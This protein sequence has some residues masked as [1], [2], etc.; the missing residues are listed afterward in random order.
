MSHDGRDLLICGPSGLDVSQIVPGV[1]AGPRLGAEVLPGA[2]L[3][4]P[5]E[6]PTGLALE[7]VAGPDTGRSLPMS[8]G[9]HGIGRGEIADPALS[10]RHDEVAV[11][12][13]GVVITDAGST[14]G[15]VLLDPQTDTASGLVPGR[16][17]RLDIGHELLAGDSRL[18]LR[19][20]GAAPP[21]V[22]VDGRVAYARSP[23][24]I[25]APAAREFEL[26]SPPT[27][28]TRAPFPLVTV[29]LP[30]LAAVPLAFFMHSPMWLL[31]GLLSPVMMLGNH[32]EARRTGRH[33]GRRERERVAR[34]RRAVG[35]AM[36]RAVAD[37][38][39]WRAVAFPD[40]AEIV[41]LCTDRTERLWER[42][43]TDED[44]LTV[45]VGIG[46]VASRHTVRG[47]RRSEP[48]TLRETPV[49]LSL[50]EFPLVGVAGPAAGGIVSGWLLQLVALHSPVAMELHVLGVEDAWAWIRW[51][52]H[53]WDAPA[54]RIAADPADVEE[55]L[56][57][58]AALVDSRTTPG[59]V[60]ADPGPRVVVL[61]ADPGRHRHSEALQRLLTAGP[62]A[63]VSL[64][65][66]AD[67]AEDLPGDLAVVVS[68][69]RI[70][71][72]D[73]PAQPV[74]VDR[75]APDVAEPAARALAP[76]RDVTPAGRGG[77]LPPAVGLAEVLGL[78]LFDEEALVDAVTAAWQAPGEEAVLGMLA[79]GPW[80]VDLRRDGPHLLIAGT[81]GSGKSELLRTLVTSLALHNAPDHLAFVLVDYKGGA[82]FGACAALPHVTGV[83]TDLDQAGTAR[84]IESLA[85]EIRRREGLLAAAGVADLDAYRRS[86]ESLP[87][88]VV[89]LDE[90]RVL[91]EEQPE[92]LADLVRLATVGRSLGL[93]LV[94]ATQRPGGVVSA[95]MN[96]NLNLRIALRVQNPTESTDVLGLPDA[97][98][99]PS[100]TPGRA[101]ARIG[102]EPAA[103]FQ[104]A[105][106]SGGGTGQAT[107]TAAPWIWHGQPPPVQATHD[108]A[109][110]RR[111][112][113]A[114]STAARRTG[115]EPCAP[116]WL[117]PLPAVI[118]PPVA[119]AET[120]PIRIALGRADVPAR[121]AQPT[122]WWEPGND[123]HLLVAGTSRSGRT[124]VLRTLLDDSTS[125]F[126]PD[127][128]W[129]YVLDGGGALADLAPRPG[130]GAVV[131]ADDHERA[132][133]LLALLRRLIAGRT[134]AAGHPA[135]LLLVDSWE[136]VR[137]GR[138]DVAG[139]EFLDDLAA[140]LRD[141]PRVGVH[142]VV[143]GGRSVLTG[144]LAAA[145]PAR[146]LLRP[147]D[148]SDL[149]L[150]GVRAK[151]A[152]SPWPV[153]RGLL[154]GRTADPAPVL[155]QVFRPG[156]GWN[157][158]TDGPGAPTVP[159]MPEHV[160]LH[161]VAAPPGT[162]VLG[163]G[164]D[165]V[166]PLG[167]DP[168]ASPLLVAG[169][170]GTGRTTA[171]TTVATQALAAGWSVVTNTALPL[172][173]HPHLFAPDAADVQRTVEQAPG[174]VLMV[175]DH[176]ERC[177][178]AW[179]E[180]VN[181]AMSGPVV[182]AAAGT[183]PGLVS[184]FSGPVVELR[185]R[186]SVVLLGP[187]ARADTDLV[188][189]RATVR[190]TR[191]PGRGL[192]AEHG[193]LTPIQVVTSGRPRS[194]QPARRQLA[195]VQMPSD[196]G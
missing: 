71:Y 144:Q 89:V 196:P 82:A 58:L 145:V 14:N 181:R 111:L 78:D 39:R 183:T 38:K 22:P 194:Q 105:S 5:T 27:T 91:A 84:V 187:A 119:Q 115:A 37:E 54:P 3:D 83:V 127:R 184:C 176:V 135:V 26:P 36:R 47:T 148:V 190:H 53:L 171:L 19:H 107:P 180:A 152:P 141:G 125:R 102:S 150:A 44:A 188:D 63:G 64:L 162:W 109:N 117:P 139:L 118:E 8:A 55:A 48:V 110:L 158:G 25:V 80:S 123:G 94:L 172:D 87:R 159:V 97:A 137:A 49:S 114:V 29:L 166:L 98:H 154:V 153:G 24:R 42:A 50:V 96:A 191:A 193:R 142:V 75:V 21:I 17:T 7:V 18:T 160:S 52:P 177:A 175:V 149:T 151:D 95:E 182:I 73:A 120:G 33:A 143:T 85:T 56:Q 167:W 40:V 130:L 45:R 165:D 112:V 70:H 146:L 101:I 88:L 122:L 61:L 113:E 179:E 138:D 23:R 34:R 31:F 66:V 12:P 43:A 195:P 116:V 104:V 121:Q 72:R 124:G 106:V 60:K 164:G 51:A 86:G 185:R 140:V 157:G 1:G 20:R 99:L 67:E 126:G 15:T 156:R 108:D 133:R 16:P 6:A 35:E 69:H 59:T 32:L 90:F 79:E 77:T 46:S 92:A 178:A 192:L 10:R 173:A 30:L 155:M 13:T 170:P 136:G 189:V 62:A 41:R 163:V 57:R 147:A 68:R 186:A 100:G 4:G 174:R 81:T 76:V 161:E 65:V 168:D 93:H 169:H 2:V 134:D 129:A 9:R 74:L 132:A 128:L 103:L 11:A 131:A 28:P